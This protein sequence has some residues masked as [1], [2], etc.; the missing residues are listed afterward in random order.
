MRSET[1]DPWIIIDN[2]TQNKAFLNE[3]EK[4]I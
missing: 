2:Y 1:K 3:L 4:N